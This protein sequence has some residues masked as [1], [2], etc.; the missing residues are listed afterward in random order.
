MLLRA[1]Y[2]LVRAPDRGECLHALLCS[3]VLQSALELRGIL[4]SI[5]RQRLGICLKK[6][7]P[8]LTQV[9]QTPSGLQAYQL[10]KQCWEKT[11]CSYAV[12]SKGMWEAATEWGYAYYGQ[13]GNTLM[14][15]F[16]M[17]LIDS[18]GL[19]LHWKNCAPVDDQQF[20][21]YN[22]LIPQLLM[23]LVQQDM[24]GSMEDAIRVIK[25]SQEW[26]DLGNSKLNK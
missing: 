1:H 5:S 21:V 8:I 24:R 9:A 15:E 22:V 4:L 25:E 20:A 2:V 11:G 13:E 6:L 3:R 14:F 23:H 7:V 16:V 17:K 26:D 18:G 12:G 19:K 10:A